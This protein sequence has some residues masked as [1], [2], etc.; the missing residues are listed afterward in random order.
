MKILSKFLGCSAILAAMTGQP[1]THA[2]EGMWLFSDPPRGILKERHQFEPTGAWMEHVQKSTVRFNSGGTGSFVSPEGLVMSNHHVGADAIQKLGAEEKNYLRDG[3]HARSRAEEL[4]CLDLELNVLMS[5]EDVTDK[6][7]AA[8]TAGMA[9]EKAFEARKSAM[10][11]IERRS[12]EET[13][14]RSDVVTLY[15]GGKYHLYRFKKY[16]D[17]RLVWAPEQQA[18]FFGGDPDNFEYPRFCLDV[19]FFRVYENGA[20]AKIDHHFKWSANGVAENELIFVSGHPGRTSRLNTMAELE[21]MRD[22]QFPALMELLH[23]WEVMYGVYSSRS[24]EN[25]R[26]AKDALFGVQNSRKAREGGLAGLLD[27]ALM[28]RKAAAE[29]ALRRAMATREDLR[30]GLKA[31]DEIAA[32]QRVIGAQATEYNLLEVG[33]GLNSRHFEIARTLAR[34]AAER[35]KPSG[36]RLREFRDSNRESLEFSLFS[37]E[38]VYDDLE[39]VTLADSLT[40]LTAKFGFSDPLVQAIL[41][42]KSPRQRAAELVLGTKV[43]TVEDRKKLYAADQAQIA[44]SDDP[45]IRLALLVDSRARAARKVIE[46]QSEIKNQAHAKIARARFAVQGA[47]NYPDA[48]FTLRL[49]FGLAK[50][51]WEG[52]RQ[53]PFQ[54]TMGGI[55]ERSKEMGNKPPFDLPDSWIQRKQAIKAGTP[56]NFVSTA[57]IIGGNSGSPVINR[58]AEIVGLIFD[59][60]IHSLVL[61]FAYSDDQ[62]RALSVNSQAIIEALR[63]IYD[64]T[65]LA[66]EILGK[67]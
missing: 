56:F 19:C 4:R 30:D 65:P 40:L 1:A 54:T 47:G 37:E 49:A 67:K 20:P 63:S 15:Q 61:D 12:L 6:V 24:E 22:T 53:F 8:V 39:Q 18:A 52:G 46:T 44:A 64:A 11:E 10:G 51:Y 41:A 33:R 50:G 9:A 35:S 66:D 45:M 26:R 13:G 25:A 55:F 42:G 58:N 62:A 34:A 16:T 17:V 2:D 38:P 48:T 60:N 59:G 21:Y 29:E 23:R 31:F 28:A 3:F 32:A 5:I 57:D 7:N 43:K 36:E 27:P 14:L